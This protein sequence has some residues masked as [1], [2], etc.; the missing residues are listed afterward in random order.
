LEAFAKARGISVLI[1]ASRVPLIY[2]A[3]NLDITRAF[4]ADYNSKNP[5]TA[6]AR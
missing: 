6:S 3:D 4:I 5:S 1:D 2:A